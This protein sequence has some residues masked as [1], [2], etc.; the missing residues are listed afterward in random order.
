MLIYTIINITMHIFMTYCVPA[1]HWTKLFPGTRYIV[2][3]QMFWPW[4]LYMFT[5]F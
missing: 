5:S 2:V 3:T 4:V 1:R